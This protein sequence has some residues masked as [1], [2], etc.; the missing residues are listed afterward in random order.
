M[1][2]ENPNFN[3]NANTNQNMENKTAEEKTTIA[4]RTSNF[5]D[6]RVLIET[7]CILGFC[8]AAATTYYFSLSFISD[9]LSLAG[10]DKNR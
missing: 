8:N 6:R 2:E 7:I 3:D 9:K 4:S 10:V 1:V 5:T